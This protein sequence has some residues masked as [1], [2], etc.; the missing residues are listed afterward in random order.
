MEPQIATPVAA[1][2]HIVHQV[3]PLS[4]YLAMTLFIVLPFV[5]GWI[6]YTYAPEKIVELEKEVIREVLVDKMVDE[7]SKANFPV[8]AFE[9]EGLLSD[10]E[11][12]ILNKKFIE[13]FVDYE[14]MFGTSTVLTTVIEVPPDLYEAYTITTVTSDGKAGGFLFGERGGDYNYWTPGCFLECE[15]TDE[16]IQ[17]HPEVIKQYKLNIQP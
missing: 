6:G 3:T 8:I 15:F 9:R 2:K 12:Q 5:G 17:K 14:L 7:S 4:K 1:E 10:Q 13:P 11:R 16:Y